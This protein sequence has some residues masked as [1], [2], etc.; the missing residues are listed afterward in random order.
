MATKYSSAETLVILRNLWDVTKPDLHLL[1]KAV[2]WQIILQVFAT[3][4]SNFFFP[5]LVAALIAQDRMAVVA[6]IIGF[7]LILRH[8]QLWADIK[9]FRHLILGF[10]AFEN[11]L[12]LRITKHTSGLGEGFFIDND[13]AKIFQRTYVYPSR[14][15]DLVNNLYWNLLNR[16]WR[17][18]FAGIAMVLINPIY[19][20]IIV[21]VLVC[22]AYSQRLMNQ[23][24]FMHRRERVDL[25][26][27]QTA[28]AAK[29]MYGYPT[30]SRAGAIKRYT[31]KLLDINRQIETK[32]S[33]ESDAFLTFKHHG[34]FR[35]I[36]LIL[37]IAIIV[38]M[39]SEQML[40]GVISI[41]KVL[42]LN[43][44][45]IQIFDELWAIADL[46]KNINDSSE[47]VAKVKQLLNTQPQERLLVTGDVPGGNF[48]FTGSFT[49]TPQSQSID[50]ESRLEDGEERIIEPIIHI[51]NLTIT[52]GQSIGIV[53]ATGAGKSTLVK[54]LCSVVG[55]EGNL[56]L[57]GVELADIDPAKYIQHIAF[58]SQ[59]VWLLNSTID[60][61]MRLGN[62][63]IAEELI[64]QALTA[65]QIADEVRA[66]GGLDTK[67]GENGRKLS[68][69]ERQRLEI[70]R[71]MLSTTIRDIRLLIV[72][73]GTSALDNETEKKI[74]SALAP[75]LQDQTSIIIAHRMTT[76]MGCD[77]V[78]VMDNGLIVERGNPHALLADTNSEFANLYYAAHQEIA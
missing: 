67:I 48:N 64:W 47:Y 33:L 52:A 65:A 7:A 9:M 18:L 4:Y 16:S 39:I 36:Y 1:K 74:Q 56:M 20:V 17:V 32:R 38:S 75:L 46:F 51:D 66:W 43:S 44:L 73:E 59:E 28:T 63:E 31:A 40:S 26:E 53:G 71:A 3:I 27:V 8:I 22:F 76:V 24:Q 2:I 42:I 6:I 12:I 77:E 14:I 21:F 60:E 35:D 54:A 41:E 37:A 69:G 50:G 13:V 58:I 57:N 78:L 15:K 10:T 45:V 5:L 68:G 11:A 19:V 70:A 55:Y 34:L 72:D 25:E 23:Y 29:L 62:S 30:I 49:V 61:N